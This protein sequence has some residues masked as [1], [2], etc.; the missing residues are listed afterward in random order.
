VID[1]VGRSI[2]HASTS[3]TGTES[4]PLAGERDQPID[5]AVRAPESSKPRRQA[6]A[7]QE[8]TKLLLDEAR[9]PLAISQVRRLRPKRLE[10]VAHELV[11]RA[12]LG[13][14]WLIGR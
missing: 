11:Q 5:P 13:P 4:S 7:R 9:Q 12:P 6:P 2:R 3:A 1:Q 8:V 10:V 14:T